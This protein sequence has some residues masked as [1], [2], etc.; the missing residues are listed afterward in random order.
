LQQFARFPSPGQVKTRLHAAL[1]AGEACAV[2]EALLLQTARTLT[3]SGLGAAELWLDCT[4]AHETLIEAERIGMQGPFLQAGDDLG[5]R[6]YNALRDG[7]TRAASVVL[8]G[9]DCPDLSAGYLSAA[10]AALESED[11]VLGPADDGGFV[12][13]GC[14]R[15]RPGMFEGV[16]W[17]GGD[18]L[19]ATRRALQSEGLHSAVLNTLYDVDTPEDLLRWRASQSQA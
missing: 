11:V 9:S 13:I 4:D 12:L 19:K 15:L 18:V 1:S 3:A 14:R 8:V 7:L 10:F 16:V 2:H 6:M 17:G 5:A